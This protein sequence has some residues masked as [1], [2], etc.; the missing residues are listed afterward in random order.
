MVGNIRGFKNDHFFGNGKYLESGRENVHGFEYDLGVRIIHILHWKKR[1][2][3]SNIPIWW[4]KRNQKRYQRQEF[5]MSGWLRGYIFTIDTR[6][7]RKDIDSIYTKKCN[8]KW[9]NN[10]ERK[11]LEMA[12]LNSERYIK[13]FNRN[14]RIADC[15]DAQFDWLFSFTRKYDGCNRKLKVYLTYRHFDTIF[16]NF[17]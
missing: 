7:Y 6:E 14:D 4:T 16:S 8:R 5:L 2:K 11:K 13:H 15:E 12:F 1:K 3:Q 9:N 17:R 10:T